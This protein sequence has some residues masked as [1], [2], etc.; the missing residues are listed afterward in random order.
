MKRRFAPLIAILLV[1]GTFGNFLRFVEQEPDRMAAFDTIPLTANG[2]AGTALRFSEQSYDI[3]QAD[4]TTL[5]RYIDSKGRRLW[6]FIAYFSSQKYGSQIHSPKLCL[7][8]VG[9]RIQQIEPYRLELAGGH[10]REV[11][12]LV[13]SEGDSRQVMFY[14]FETRGGTIRNEFGLKFSLM[15]NSLLL[16]PTDAAI[17][18]LTLAISPGDNL[19]STTARAV[20]YLNVFFPSISG[21][22]PFGAS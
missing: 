1:A 12:R 9:W 11:N 18:R 8:G 3:L 15:K 5:R 22:L 6:L 13:I 4:T 17:I 14:W 20:E 2:Y 7:P 16:R 10:A 19:E 21:A